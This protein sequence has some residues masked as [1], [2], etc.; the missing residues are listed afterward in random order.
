MS[1]KMF[2][3]HRHIATASLTMTTG[4]I[5]ASSDPAGRGPVVL[6]NGAI[7]VVVF[8]RLIG[9]HFSHHEKLNDIRGPLKTRCFYRDT[10]TRKDY[11]KRL[12][13]AFLPLKLRRV[14]P[15]QIPT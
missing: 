5:L 8:I 14:I 6:D 4:Y 15:H 12:K 3:G 7:H 2:G 1:G 11:L 13:G 10:D 9:K